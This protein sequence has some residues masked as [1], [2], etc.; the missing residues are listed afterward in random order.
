M[1]GDIPLLSLLVFMCVPGSAKK[2]SLTEK[3]K[4]LMKAQSQT[5]TVF[6]SLI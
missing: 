6:D 4:R 3:T 5:F 2:L 1:T